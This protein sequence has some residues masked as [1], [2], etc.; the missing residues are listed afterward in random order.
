MRAFLDRLYRLSGWIAAGFIAAICAL[1]FAQVVLNIIDR[2]SSLITGQAV[3]LSIPSYSDFTGFFLASASFFALAYTLR[4]GGHIRVTL[5]IQHAR[6]GARWLIEFW[7]VGLA[8]TVSVYFTWYMA[9]LV[10]ESH[11][12]ND[13]S[14]GM[15]PVPIW[16]PQ[17]GMLIGL[18]VLSIALIDELYSLI[19]GENP[20]YHDKGENLLEGEEP[21]AD[22]IL[23]AE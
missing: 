4:E 8:C 17:T 9:R 10:L 22:S 19:R 3:G 2:V 23:D 6:S 5:F 12:F 7:C 11:E 1:V 16:I 13:L 20:S 14:S 18:V 21:I 15:I